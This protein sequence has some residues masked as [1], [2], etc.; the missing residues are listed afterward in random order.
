MADETTV[1]TVK[2]GKYIYVTH[3]FQRSVRVD[4]KKHEENKFISDVERQGYDYV[5]DFRLKPVPWD[6]M[7]KADEEWPEMWSKTDR[8]ALSALFVP[9]VHRG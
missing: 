3:E 4:W 7:D 9:K 1:P 6:E 5:G 8:F 2:F